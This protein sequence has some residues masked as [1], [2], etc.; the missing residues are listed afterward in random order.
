MTLPSFNFKPSGDSRVKLFSRTNIFLSL[1]FC[2]V[3]GVTTKADPLTFSNVVALQNGGNSSVDLFSNPGTTVYGSPLSF[4][5]HVSG[6]LSPGQ[7]DSLLVTYADAGGALFSQTFDIPLF[8]SVSPPFDL[9]FTVQSPTF[10]YQGVAATLTVDLLNTPLDFVIPSGPNSG[11]TVN[12]YS[13]SFNVAQ[14]VPEP[15][16]ITLLGVSILGIATRRRVVR[17]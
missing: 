9:I 10:S 11:Q 16:S 8:G 3:L 5:I 17:K 1:L 2:L 7:V 6:T 13:Y 15:A 14:P 4:S 12:S